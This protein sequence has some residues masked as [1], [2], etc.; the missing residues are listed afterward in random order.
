MVTKYSFRHNLT[1]A[2]K[3]KTSSTKVVK[4]YAH[5]KE[6]QCIPQNI[7]QIVE[8]RSFQRIRVLHILALR[9]FLIN[10]SK[11]SGLHGI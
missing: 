6:I 10:N 7:I 11:L 9:D 4:E 3:Q 1:S 5:I 2:S 8:K